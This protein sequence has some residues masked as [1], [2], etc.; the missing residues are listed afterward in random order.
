MS[1]NNLTIECLGVSNIS[2]NICG[3]LSIDLQQ[4]DVSFLEDVKESDI[5]L[6]ANNEKLLNEMDAEEVFEWVENKFDVIIKGN[7]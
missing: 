5:I 6:Y 4:V 2:A 7:K 3:V 1:K